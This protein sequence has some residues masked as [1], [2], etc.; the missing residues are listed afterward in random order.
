MQHAAKTECLHPA[1]YL[2]MGQLLMTF[3]DFDDEM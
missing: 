2:G 3:D 1:T